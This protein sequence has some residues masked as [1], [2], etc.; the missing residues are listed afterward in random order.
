M[1]NAMFGTARAGRAWAGRAWATRL[2]WCGPARHDVARRG[3]ARLGGVGFGEAR[4]GPTDF[5]GSARCRL[6]LLGQ[7]RQGG[8]H[9]VSGA[10]H[11]M[12]RYGHARHALARRG[13]R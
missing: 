13:V 8:G 3:L 7:S 2:P 5:L 4:Q 9:Q 10:W 12:V 11:G 6:T 1:G